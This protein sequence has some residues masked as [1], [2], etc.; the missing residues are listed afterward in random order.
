MAIKRIL[1]NYCLALIEKEGDLEVFE[2]LVLKLI[3]DF[4]N[5][6]DYIS[7]TT[8]ASTIN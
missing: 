2:A 6:S 5:I 4:S 1:L 7:K 3:K 8:D